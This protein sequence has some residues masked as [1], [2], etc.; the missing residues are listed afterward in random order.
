[1]VGL[2]F[3]SKIS[4]VLWL[5]SSRW[6]IVIPLIVLSFV[7]LAGVG[8]FALNVGGDSDKSAVYFATTSFKEERSKDSAEVDIGGLKSVF[9]DM[10]WNHD[11]A[12]EEHQIK[13]RMPE[14]LVAIEQVGYRKEM[15]IGVLLPVVIRSFKKVMRSREFLLGVDEKK[16]HLNKV[17]TKRVENLCKTY[18]LKKS[19][20]KIDNLLLRVDILPIS[21]VLAQAAIES[22]WGRSRFTQEGNALF[23]QWTTSKYRG[24]T[25]NSRDEGKTHK[26]RY[27]DNIE[28]SVDSYIR[29]LNSHPA[30]EDFRKERKRQR[31][32]SGKQNGYLKK[33]SVW[34]LLPF[35]KAYSQ[36]G[37]EYLDTLEQIIRVNHFEY[38]E[39]RITIIS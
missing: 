13:K 25:P 6:R 16:L 30:Y 5:F 26:I 11:L 3:S 20:C 27:Y 15:F 36:R 31:K 29:N 9:R 39:N 22:G 4:H 32:S 17:D 12:Y 38:L 34:D 10:G 8:Y 7:V 21:L 35:L 37:K 14:A 28:A 24:I 23:G 1:M 18:R 33:G 2:C 19:L